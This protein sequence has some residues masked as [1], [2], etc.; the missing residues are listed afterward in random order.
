MTVYRWYTPLLHLDTH[1]KLVQYIKLAIQEC[2]LGSEM[3]R[4]PRL[5][6]VGDGARG[7]SWASSA[8]AIADAAEVADRKVADDVT[9]S[10]C[11]ASG[12]RLPHRRRADARRRRRR[13][14][15]RRAAAWPSAATR[16][17]ERVRRLPL[18]R[19]QRAARLGRAW[20]ARCSC[21]PADPTCAAGV[22]FFNNVGYLGMCGHG[23]IGV[24]VD[25]G[26]PGPDRAGRRTA[27]RRR[28]ASS[29]VDS[30]RRQ[31]RHRRERAELSP[32]PGDV[33]VEV[34]GHRPRHRRRRLGR[35][36]VLPRR[37]TTARRSTLANVE[38]ADRLHLARSARR[39]T[40]QGITGADGGGDR[41]HR[42]VRPAARPGADSRNFVLC[43]GKAYDRSPCGTGTSAKLACLAAD[44]KLRR[45]RGLAAGE[46]HRQRLRGARASL[47]DG[48]V[49]P[50]ITGSAYVN[51]EATLLLDPRRPVPLGIRG[52]FE[53]ADSLI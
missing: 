33:A 50:R 18:G 23:T 52:T 27:S 5:P 14:R 11:I 2:G 13:A 17:R 34:P 21:E 1:V 42:A 31:P 53:A 3:V 32:S 4:A 9:R 35:Q 15:P 25:A 24:A 30:R 46:H 41:P 8:A 45:G 44:G 26:P 48:E 47:A 36:L 12:D 10:T 38:R 39:L 51:A 28:S 6:L 43:P 49:I 40:A 20:S 16:F 29:T 7:R 19:R 22:I 37:A